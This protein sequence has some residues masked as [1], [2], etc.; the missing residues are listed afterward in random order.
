MTREILENETEKDKKK[1]LKI[2]E[3]N[4]LFFLEVML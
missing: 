2:T 3:E 1:Y 4:E